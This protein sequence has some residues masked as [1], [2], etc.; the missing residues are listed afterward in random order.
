MRVT[1]GRK[2]NQSEL[3]EDIKERNTASMLRK[4]DG[5][6]FK[7]GH[8]CK[9][10]HFS[11]LDMTESTKLL[12]IGHRKVRRDFLCGNTFFDVDKGGKEEDRGRRLG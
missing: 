4:K 1:N 10:Y 5:G 11:L 3:F 7:H 6:I 8:L 12:N 2:G 9:Y